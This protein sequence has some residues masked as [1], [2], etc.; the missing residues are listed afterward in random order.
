[1]GA[2]D[3]LLTY[4][5]YGIVKGSIFGLIGMGLSLIYGIL[6]ILNFAHGEFLMLGAYVAFF[7]SILGVNPIVA[8]LVSGVS[9][10]VIGVI[11]EK[12]IIF[13]I[14]IRAT[15]QLRAGALISTFG[16]SIAL[17]NAALWMWG[18]EYRGAD[19][20]KGSLEIAG[21]PVS[22]ERA[23]ICLISIIVTVLFWIFINKTKLGKAIRAVAQ[24][25]EGASL[26]GINT[27]RIY[28]ITFGLGGMFA[29]LAGALLLPIYLAY[30][31]VGIHPLDTAFAV[32]ILGGLGSIEGAIL[33]GIVLGIAQSLT[34]GYIAS[35]YEP[36]VS[37]AI[38]IAVL[39]IRPK[40]LFGRE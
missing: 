4:I 38:I 29:G 14:R 37:F 5:F 9:V 13:P 18:G 20:W 15:E 8:I 30:P 34:S 39:V 19:Y 24:S 3:Q 11:I 17:Q 21:I 33:G 6:H 16:L 28:A 26:M 22:I 25:R 2:L 35:S 31:T 23:L 40:G 10:F 1:M 12:A 32:V 27:N 7:M 36:L